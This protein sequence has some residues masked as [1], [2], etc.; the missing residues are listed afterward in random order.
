MT[1]LAVTGHMDLTDETVPL[2]RAALRDLLA[3][4]SGDLTGVSCIAA[5]SDSLFAEEVTA[6]GGRLVAVIPSED[7][8]ATKVKPGHAAVFDHLVETAG[9]VVTLPHT[10]ASRA[11][12]EAANAEL[13]RRADRLV[14][15]WDGTPPSGK[16]G[17]TADTV[18]QA[19][20]AGLAVDVVW[21][22]GAARRGR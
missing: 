11:A 5:G 17:G 14:A 10:T 16:G 18:G 13:L 4:Y 21:P 2:V 3:E 9:E 8:R 1:T 6:I 7:Y 22:A 19:R 20:Q 15:V 12:Y